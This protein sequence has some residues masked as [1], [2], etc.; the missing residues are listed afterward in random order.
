MGKEQSKKKQ[1]ER[2]LIKMIIEIEPARNTVH[3][4]DIVLAGETIVGSPCVAWTI[5]ITN[6]SA[7][8][9]I[10]NISDS[11]TY[12]ATYRIL[13]VAVPAA[14]TLFLPFPKGMKFTR[15]V[16]AA[17]NAGSIDIDITYD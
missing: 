11:T 14:T 9:G 17:A 15:G 12:N 5:T 2:F 4:E 3:N 13:K 8:A 6:D 1:E 10:V 16:S 7:T